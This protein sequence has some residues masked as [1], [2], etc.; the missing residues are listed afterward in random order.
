MHMMGGVNTL[1]VARDRVKE[2]VKIASG[3][4]ERVRQR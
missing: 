3:S 2:G 4:E 1:R